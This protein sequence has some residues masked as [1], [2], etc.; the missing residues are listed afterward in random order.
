LRKGRRRADNLGE[1]SL[2]AYSIRRAPGALLVVLVVIWL[3]QFGVWQI[4]ETPTYIDRA[5]QVTNWPHFLFPSMNFQ[6]GAANEWRAGASEV[7]LCLLAL[8]GLGAAWRLRKRRV[9]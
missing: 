2:L 4:A 6:P 1:M 7:V 8:L 3:I 5:G 9:R